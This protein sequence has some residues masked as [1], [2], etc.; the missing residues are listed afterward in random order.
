MSK[1][2]ENKL[3]ELVGA[4]IGDGNIW[5]KKYEIVITGDK[6]NDA[7]YFEFLSEVIEQNFGYK[8][9]IKY[10]S[11]ALRLVIRSKKI[12]TFLLVV[13]V[14]TLSFAQTVFQSNLSSWAAGNPTDWMGTAT[15][16][17]SANVVEQTFG[18][19][20]GTSMASLI[21]ATTTHKRFTTLPVTVT[22]GETYLIEM[23]V[24]CQTSGEL[25]TNY[26]D[27]TNAVYGSYNSYIDVA[28]T[29]AGNLVLVSQT[30]T[31]PAGCTSAEFILS[32]RNTDPA[33]AGSPFFIGILVDSVAI[34]VS[35][36]PV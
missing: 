3:S 5:R 33:T 23:W 1:M 34:T 11:G 32:L 21:N 30:V 19:T 35:A 20:Y 9:R 29:S 8:P 6:E 17:A 12:F 13:C 22:P 27:A 18:A 7:G 14:G 4:I 24:A 25:R 36:P 28:A 2:N 15:N 10:R 26:Y 16:I 31:L